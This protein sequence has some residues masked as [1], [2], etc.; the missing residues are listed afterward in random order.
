MKQTK[1]PTMKTNTIYKVEN[2]L[3]SHGIS[4]QSITTPNGTL[5]MADNEDGTVTPFS[6]NVDLKKVY[7]FLGY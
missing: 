5:I 4:T 2:I 1:Q 3:R 6:I 7:E